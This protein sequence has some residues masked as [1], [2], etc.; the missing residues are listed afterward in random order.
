M[1]FKESHKLEYLVASDAISI[2]SST[3]HDTIFL[4]TRFEF[5]NV[6]NAEC[7]HPPGH[8]ESSLWTHHW[9]VQRQHL[10]ITLSE[11][12]IKSQQMSKEKSHNPRSYW[13]IRH[14]AKIQSG[15]GRKAS[16]KWILK[17]SKAEEGW[18]KNEKLGGRGFREGEIE[19]SG[20]NKPQSHSFRNQ[21]RP[22]GLFM[23]RSW[24]APFN[25]TA[26]NWNP[27]KRKVISGIIAA[28]EVPPR[29]WGLSLQG[30]GRV[31]SLNSVTER[32]FGTA[33][34]ILNN[35]ISSTQRCHHCLGI[36][37][38]DPWEEPGTSSGAAAQIVI[39]HPEKWEFPS[40]KSK[41]LLLLLH[42]S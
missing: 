20:K 26:R 16:T 3:I 6:E 32:G 25:F 41:P 19:Q 34:S 22:S 17:M 29:A 28:T 15:T 5:Y 1:F 30:K 14:E 9:V 37:G 18:D 7:K 23:C 38:G 36:P 13:G 24:K 31:L 12:T 2:S 39:K 4:L 42:F 27:R 11:S 40:C 21:N 33:K 10:I 35:W 8:Q